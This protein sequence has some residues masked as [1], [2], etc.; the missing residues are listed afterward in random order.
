MVSGCGSQLRYA[1]MGLP[2]GGTMTRPV[3]LDFAVVLKV[4]E[5][6]EADAQLLARV[7]PGVEEAIVAGMRDDVIEE[8]ERRD[9]SS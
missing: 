3:G 9:G 5:A 7:L 4:G 2:M 8:E 1:T 6:L